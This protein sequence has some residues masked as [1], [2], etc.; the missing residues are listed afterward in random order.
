MALIT[1]ISTGDLQIRCNVLSLLFSERESGSGL[2]GLVIF[3]INI[4]SVMIVFST[5]ERYPFTTP[6]ENIFLYNHMTF[7]VRF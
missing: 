3:I 7:F 2:L 4:S 1:V 5:L 6:N